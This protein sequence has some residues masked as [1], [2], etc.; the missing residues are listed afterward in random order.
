MTSSDAEM[1]SKPI[2]INF[3]YIAY[4]EKNKEGHKKAKQTKNYI[5]KQKQRHR[6]K[7]MKK[8]ADFNGI[9]NLTL[10]RRTKVEIKE[11]EKKTGDDTHPISWQ[12][13]SSASLRA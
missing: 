10:Q 13:S 9:E 1:D 6:Q 2:I 8:H 3:F 4:T 11:N 5:N 12:T 7:Q